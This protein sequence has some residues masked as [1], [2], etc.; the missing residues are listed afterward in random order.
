MIELI[1]KAFGLKNDFFQKSHFFLM[2][3]LNRMPHI[4]LA[5]QTIINNPMLMNPDPAINA[6]N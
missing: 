6:G 2:F 1:Y 4:M 3:L 5:A